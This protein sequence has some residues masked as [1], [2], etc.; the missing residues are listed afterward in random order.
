MF[1]IL[2]VLDVVAFDIMAFDVAALDIT[3]FGILQL[4]YLMGKVACREDIYF[5]IVA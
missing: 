4:F 1:D 5:A 3:V 2:V